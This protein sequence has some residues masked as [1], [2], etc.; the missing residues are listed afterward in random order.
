MKKN[1]NEAIFSRMKPGNKVDYVR[2]LSSS[3]L[4]NVKHDTII[5]CIKEVGDKEYSYHIDKKTNE[6]VKKLTRNKKLSLSDE[7]SIGNDWNSTIL[8]INYIKSKLFVNIYFQM[9]STDRNFLVDYDKFFSV[10][11][12]EGKCY[13]MNRYGDLVPR[14]FRYSQRMKE[15]AIKNILLEY[16][17]KKYADKLS[18]SV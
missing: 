2:L 4:M 12:Y 16:V 5:R 6:S 9:D 8:G 10:G 17:Y 18:Q 13:E 14:Y 3:E 11:D 15:N 7:R 1:V